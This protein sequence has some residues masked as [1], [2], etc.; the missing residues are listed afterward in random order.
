[1]QPNTNDC[2]LFAIAFAITISSG[3]A[4]EHL[5]FDVEQMR[6]HLTS[7][8]EKK[9]M[10]PFPLIE[11]VMREEKGQLGRMRQCMACKCR[12]SREQQDGVL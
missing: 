8:F 4:P 5:L 12:H 11:E 2:G 6:S 7:C 10:K 9:E 1:M 3:Q